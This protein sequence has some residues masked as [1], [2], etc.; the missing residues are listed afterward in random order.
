MIEDLFFQTPTPPVQ[1]QVKD[2]NGD[3]IQL[4]RPQTALYRTSSGRLFSPKTSRPQL[5]RRTPSEDLR[6]RRS[7]AIT[8]PT[9]RVQAR[10]NDS[11]GDHPLFTRPQPTLLRTSTGAPLNPKTAGDS[12]VL[13]TPCEDRRQRSFVDTEV[14]SNADNARLETKT[15]IYESYDLRIEYRGGASNASNHMS[16][17]KTQGSRADTKVVELE[18][19]S[20]QTGHR[21][22]S[23]RVI[24]KPDVGETI[25]NMML[26]PLDKF[27]A[28]AQ[29]PLGKYNL[30][31]ALLEEEVIVHPSPARRVVIVEPK[32]NPTS[33]GFLP[34]PIRNT[35]ISSKDHRLS[36]QPTFDQP[37]TIRPC[38]AVLDHTDMQHVMKGAERNHTNAMRSL[39]KMGKQTT[40]PSRVDGAARRPSMKV[41]MNS[42]CAY[43]VEKHDLWCSIGHEEGRAY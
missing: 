14:I 20:L 13:H 32:D 7:M 2:I 43:K 41:Q 31:L 24:N 40:N 38:A 3:P 33:D 9:S 29:L 1:A 17:L 39:G 22:S 21:M 42:T 37:K 23:E 30:L 10:T 26:S 35:S 16:Y 15:T 28:I 36:R 18:S 6:Q 25:A 27:R 11:N 19:Q 34:L 5:A 12:F 4:G 8:A